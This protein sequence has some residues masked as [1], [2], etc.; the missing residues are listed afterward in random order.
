MKEKI[1]RKKIKREEE[2]RGMKY[3]IGKDQWKKRDRELMEKKEGV[4]RNHKGKNKN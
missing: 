1:K 3:M 2:E 4:G